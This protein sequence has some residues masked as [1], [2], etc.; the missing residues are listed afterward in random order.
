MAE[1]TERRLTAVLAADGVGY[2]R[3]MGVDEEG[4]LAQLKLRRSEPI[5]PRITEYRER[6]VKTTGDGV[7]VEFV[8]VVEAVHCA[9]DIQRGMVARNAEVPRDRATFRGSP[10]TRPVDVARN[11]EAAGKHSSS[12]ERRICPAK[13]H[14]VSFGTVERPHLTGLF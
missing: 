9:V 12:C 14:G 3:M 1:R 8:S 5:D 7:L 11:V 4:T 13:P 10:E 2:S 6:I